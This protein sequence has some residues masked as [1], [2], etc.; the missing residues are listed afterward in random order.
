MITNPRSKLVSL[1]IP[2]SRPLSEV[3]LK[4]VLMALADGINHLG[5]D[6]KDIKEEMKGWFGWLRLVSGVI[7]VTVGVSF[8]GIVLPLGI[9]LWRQSL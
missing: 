7:I 9:A 6:M 5:E 2:E 3:E 8:L 4:T 1:D